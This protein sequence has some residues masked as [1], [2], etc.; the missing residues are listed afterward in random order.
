MKEE[1]RKTTRLKDHYEI[2]CKKC[3]KVLSGS[4]IKQARHN[5]KMHEIFC[6]GVKNE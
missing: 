6:K 5:F 1:I 3:G 4:S 2:T